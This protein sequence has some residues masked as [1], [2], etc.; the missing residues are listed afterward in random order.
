MTDTKPEGNH[1]KHTPI[2]TGMNMACLVAIVFLFGM[3]LLPQFETIWSQGPIIVAC[4]WFIGV[5]VGNV[6]G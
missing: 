1:R 4:A 2:E 3:L 5:L 6:F